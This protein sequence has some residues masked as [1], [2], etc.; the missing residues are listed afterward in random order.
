MCV[1]L[2]DNTQFNICPED[3][4]VKLSGLVANSAL[5]STL[6]KF[7]HF[8]PWREGKQLK[9]R[10]LGDFLDGNPTYLSADEASAIWFHKSWRIGHKDKIGSFQSDIYAISK[11]LPCPTSEGTKWKYWTG[12]GFKDA[13]DHVIVE[14][15]S[16]KH[17]ELL[18]RTV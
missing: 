11:V 1:L 9:Y 2:A 10:H 3:I 14:P 18:V 4:A 6:A 16:G 15:Y 13:G 7:G 8:K 5:K 12:N 17:H